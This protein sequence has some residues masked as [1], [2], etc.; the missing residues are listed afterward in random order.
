MNKCSDNIQIL[1]QNFIPNLWL[2]YTKKNNNVIPKKTNT[3]IQTCVSD[4]FNITLWCN[5]C[6]I[7]LLKKKFL[8]CRL[9]DLLP[10]FMLH[11]VKPEPEPVEILEKLEK[12]KSR[13]RWN[14]WKTIKVNVFLLCKLELMPEPLPVLF[15]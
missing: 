12:L 8:R 4:R 10:V 11:H 7:T 13:N 3:Q 6:N 9:C 1:K 2:N 14:L 5:D 15:F